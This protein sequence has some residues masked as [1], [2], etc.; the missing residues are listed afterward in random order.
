[1]NPAVTS[2]IA[3]GVF[4]GG[5]AAAILLAI[6]ALRRRPPEVRLTVTHDAL[7]D[8]DGTGLDRSDPV[9]VRVVVPEPDGRRVS[10]QVG[11]GADP[12][13]DGLVAAQVQLDRA[14]VAPGPRE[15]AAVGT[16]TGGG[17]TGGAGTG[18]GVARGA[19]GPDNG[20]SAR[21]AD[22][23]VLG[24]VV[25][26]TGDDGMGEGASG[27]APAGQPEI[28]AGAR[29]AQDPADPPNEA[30]GAV[31][32][33]PCAA[34]RRAV[35]ERCAVARRARELHDEEAAHH[36]QLQ[37]DYDATTLRIEAAARVMDGR[38][39]LEEKETA[40][41]VFRTSRLAARSGAD[42]EIAAARWLATINE[43]NV[44]VRDAEREAAVERRRSMRL[45]AELEA[46]E[47]RLDVRRIAAET[48]E[49][50]CQ[51][52]REALAECQEAVGARPEALPATGQPA[53]DAGEG[54]APAG[55]VA[56]GESAASLAAAAAAVPAPMDVPM[57]SVAPEAGPVPVAG[58]A[59]PALTLADAP[60]DTDL[61]ARAVAPGGTI[62]SDILEG[63]DGALAWVASRLAGGVAE[64]ERRWY[65]QI[66]ALRD[67]CR[68]AAIDAGVIDLP[69]DGGFWSMFD[70][71]EARE[72]AVAL[73]S[74]GFRYDGLG[75][76]ADGRVPS[77]RD[78]SL[79][80]GY[81]GM[82]RLRIRR[83]PST[84]QLPGLLAGAT[85]PVAAFVA[86]GAPDLTLGQM[87]SLLGRQAT[88]LAALW[89]EWGRAR[90]LLA[91]RSGRAPRP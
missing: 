12:V 79:A 75:G 63:D 1:M 71:R 10:V 60:A 32:D 46:A 62:L 50:R 18:G 55:G 16:H 43:L 68:T 45:L 3:A 40:R 17:A 77:T 66:A 28:V 69:E 61:L 41:R 21:A 27:A 82:D 53:W 6:S 24:R 30:D 88:T 36:R 14:A 33:G 83:W 2:L 80:V 81:A 64:E 65:L 86:A 34:E 8:R 13:L 47:A 11:T 74:L 31:P 89:D 42:V 29:G 57:P 67:A 4:L 54:Q 84:E 73:A 15:L 22:P 59:S 72:V 44:G 7:P 9:A 70:P 51:Q 49:E 38:R 37:R 20:T 52:A 26:M 39:V 76:F 19:T 25:E 90:P 91:A 56:T 5:A 85:V 87:V 48:A 35:A 58:D 78:L 23:A